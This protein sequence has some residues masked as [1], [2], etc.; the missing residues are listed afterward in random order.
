MDHLGGYGIIMSPCVRVTV[1]WT[2]LYPA[3][4]PHIPLKRSKADLVSPYSEYG[5]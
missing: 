4:P 1:G 2:F 5:G 3:S